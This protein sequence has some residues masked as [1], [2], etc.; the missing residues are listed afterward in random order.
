MT[1]N[2]LGISKRIKSLGINNC[3]YAVLFIACFAF[4]L[5]KCQFGFGDK[6]E[7]FYLTIPLRLCQGDGLFTDEFHLSQMSSVFIYPLMKLYFWLFNDTEGIILTFRYIF[8]VL[9]AI[10]AIFLYFRLKN[11]SRSAAFVSLVYLLFTPFGIMA[12]SYNS[13]GLAFLVI[14]SVLIYTANDAPWTFYFAGLFLAGAVLC[15]PF[16]VLLYFYYFILCMYK[17]FKS[18]NEN[19]LKSS[20]VRNFGFLTLG[21]FSLAV[22]FLAFVLSRASISEIIN[23][24]P[25]IFSDPEHPSRSIVTIIYQYIRFFLHNR[26]S[27]GILCVAFILF[28]PMKF[29]KKDP[30]HMRI[31][32]LIGVLLTSIYLALIFLTGFYLNFLIF[33]FIIVG[34]FSYLLFPKDNRKEFW[35]FY[36][37]GIIYGFCMICSSNQ[38]FYVISTA[39]FVSFVGSTI[40]FIRTSGKLLEQTTIKFNIAYKSLI[41]LFLCFGFIAV[42]AGR[43]FSSFADANEL[44]RMN[45]KIE[46]GANKGI[47]TTQE[48]KS[49]YTS[50]YDGTEF[51]RSYDGDSVLYISN[52]TWLYLDDTK[53]N[54]SFS[55]W[56][57]GINDTSSDR[58]IQYYGLDEER[59]PDIVYCSIEDYKTEYSI[60][61]YLMKKNYKIS[62]TDTACIFIK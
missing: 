2:K 6:D 9:H 51:V 23:S 10:T 38:G 27:A 18:K 13:M 30:K 17:A 16:L 34:A 52:N 12:L 62:M 43:F 37:P 20:S 46:V 39:S 21:C 7:S 59:L 15:C 40:M 57:S 41:T 14:A 8:T 61:D 42:G 25:L 24:L 29:W 49:Y 53:K 1:L 56:I 22:V 58:L 36:L 11:I 50:L 33:P 5:Y 45:S 26:W 55:A 47:Y 54:A 31:F 3:V 60:F 32:L 44:W 4:V 19:I 48:K 35:C 28:L